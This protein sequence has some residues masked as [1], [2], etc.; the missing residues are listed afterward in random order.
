MNW[1]AHLYLAEDTPHAW[2]GNLVGDFARGLDP[3][4]LHPLVRAGL[5]HHR[6]ID[7]FTDAH[8]L[9]RAS[10]ARFAERFRHFSGV[11]VDLYYDHFLA[12]AWERWSTEPLPDFASRV[13]RVLAEHE[14]LLSP[15]LSAAAP[16]LERAQWLLSYR[17]DA[18][19]TRVL[20]GIESRTR[21]RTS[22]VPSLEILNTERAALQAEFDAFFPELVAAQRRW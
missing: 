11:L 13:H 14:S 16:R 2:I 6:D 22:L 17:D 20:H 12:L 3:T 9:H 18:G 21:H 5:E 7:R 10:R 4:S 19:L 8:P 15:E 1:L